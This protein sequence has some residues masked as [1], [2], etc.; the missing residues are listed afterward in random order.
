M[1]ILPSLLNNSQV[2]VEM[3]DEAIKSLEELQKLFFKVILQVPSSTPSVAFYTQTGMTELQYEVMK[4]KLN[5]I[6]NLKSLDDNT[7]AK[8]V[9][10]EQVKHK[11]PGLVKEGDNICDLIDLP[12]ISGTSLSKQEI[13]NAV[14]FHFKT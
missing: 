12:R 1:A 7:L 5:F 8:Q 11:W 9:Y 10:D 3:D 2:W 13:N 6:N 4:R 14:R